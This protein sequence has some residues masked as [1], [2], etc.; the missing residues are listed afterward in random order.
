[1]LSDFT[2]VANAIGATTKK[3]EKERLLA[4]SLDQRGNDLLRSNAA[5]E[6]ANTEL[7]RLAFKDGL[8]GLYNHRAFQ[9]RL[10]LGGQLGDGKDF[11]GFRQLVEEGSRGHV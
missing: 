11:A 6:K 3:N 7:R 9:E 10:H 4:Q 8:T 5:L 2:A 1:M